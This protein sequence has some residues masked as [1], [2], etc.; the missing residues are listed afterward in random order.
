MI[1]DGEQILE[2][3]DLSWS[4]Q[5]MA[6]V[7]QPP[8]SIERIML[9]AAMPMNFPLDTLPG[10]VECV[11]GEPRDMER[12]H[13]RDRV[14]DRFSGSGLEPRE[15]VHRHDLD[16]LAEALGLAVEPGL[17]DLLRAALDH[18]QQPGRASLVADRGQVDDH[19]HALLAG[20]GVTLYMLVDS[21]DC[22]VVET[23]G[24]VDEQPLALGEDSVVSSVPS[25]SNRTEHA[26]VHGSR[27]DAGAPDNHSHDTT[28]RARLADKPARPRQSQ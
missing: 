3:L 15:S 16:S 8:G 5:L 7:E 14:R 21:D 2:S 20:T 10:R 11:A 23:A 12:V 19:S 17:E 13:D 28:D 1:I 25:N 22:H 24:L 6:G 18:R 4:E 27:C 26:P 9:A